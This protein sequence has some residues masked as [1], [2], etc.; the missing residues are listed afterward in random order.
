[1]KNIFILVIGQNASGKSTIS[2]EIES[3]L[4]I[5]K[6]SLDDVR[7]LLISKIRFYS[8]TH[9][10][11]PN[12]KIDSVNKLVYAFREQLVKEL[13]SNKQSIVV[14]GGGII[15]KIRKKHLS[16]AKNINPK[17]ITVIIE[18]KIEEKELLKRLSKRD[19][20][21]EKLKWVK[22]YKDIRKRAYEP[23]K[24]T[25]ADCVLEYNQKNS[26]EIIKKLRKII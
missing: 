19:L 26:K 6:I 11:Y 22:F 15:R 13:L 12:K 8:D 16:L 21:N 10:S 4:K 9:Y 23:V 24:N 25:E 2:R 1:M 5:N 17:I 7:D 18:T 3:K 20:K 14:D